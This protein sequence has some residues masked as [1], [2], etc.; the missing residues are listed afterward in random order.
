MQGG[1]EGDGLSSV[2]TTRGNVV[3]IL[4]LTGIEGGIPEPE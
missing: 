4:V 3:N 1:G 2:A